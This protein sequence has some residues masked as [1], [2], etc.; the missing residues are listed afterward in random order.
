MSHRRENK[1]PVMIPRFA[2]PLSSLGY[3]SSRPTRSPRRTEDGGRGVRGS[4]QG[5]D[6]HTMNDIVD[7]NEEVSTNGEEFEAGSSVR[8]MDARG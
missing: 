8:L 6:K 7:D 5:R 1:I 4:I 2:E 3:I